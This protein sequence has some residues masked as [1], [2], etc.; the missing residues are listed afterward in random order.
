MNNTPFDQTYMYGWINEG[1]NYRI[2]HP[3]NSWVFNHHNINRLSSGCLRFYRY[4]VI[5]CLYERQ[6]I[7]H[8]ISCYFRRV[9]T[10]LSDSLRHR[11]RYNILCSIIR[12]IIPKFTKKRQLFHVKY[13]HVQMDIRTFSSQLLRSCTFYIVPNCF[14]KHRFLKKQDNFTYLINQKKPKKRL[15]LKWT[16]FLVMIIQLFLFLKGS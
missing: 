8:F 1:I 2:T 6:H 4:F 11:R 10:T 9:F 16:D 14:R 15:Y 13:Q 3:L 7:T 5:L 12:S